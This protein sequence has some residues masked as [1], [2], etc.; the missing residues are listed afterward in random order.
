MRDK[1]YKI[2]ASDALNV[3]EFMSEG[4][5][6]RILKLVKYTETNV[7]NI[8]N[9][10]FGD[11][12]GET[13]DFDDRVISDNNDSPRILATVAATIIAFTDEYPNAWIFATGSTPSRTRLYKMGIARYLKEILENFEIFGLED[14]GSWVVFEINRSYDAFLITRK[15]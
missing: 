5:K 2:Q 14:D 6:G 13:N 7:R 15:K 1:R 9:L 12:I 3:Y 10:G 4:P 8:Y 11:K